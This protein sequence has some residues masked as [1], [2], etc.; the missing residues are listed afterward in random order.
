MRAGSYSALFYL[1]LKCI[2]LY[3]IF[4]FYATLSFYM[5]SKK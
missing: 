1:G 3:N 2:P 5:M 4:K